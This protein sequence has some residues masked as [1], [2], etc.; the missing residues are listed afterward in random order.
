MSV[1]EEEGVVASSD[2]EKVKMCE[3]KFKAVH[4]G[5]NIGK[6][7]VRKRNETLRPHRHKLEVKDD[8]IDVVNLYFSMAELCKT[9]KNGGRTG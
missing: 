4:S 6:E 5:T 1:L 7:G 2:T 9:I 3:N 8:D